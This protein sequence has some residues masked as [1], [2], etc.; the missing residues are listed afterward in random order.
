MS[1]SKPN[2]IPEEFSKIINDFT[3]DILITFPEYAGIIGKWWNS[4]NKDVILGALAGTN[5]VIVAYDEL[6][7]FAFIAYI[8]NV[9]VLPL[10]TPVV[11]SY[12]VTPFTVF[13]PETFT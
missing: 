3:S 6:V 8:T 9:Y 7:P 13:D 11:K 10:E 1:E 4:D 2:N 12:V 5:I